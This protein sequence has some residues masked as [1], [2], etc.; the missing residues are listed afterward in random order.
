MRKLYSII[1]LSFFIASCSP[2]LGDN[3]RYETSLEAEVTHKVSKDLNSHNMLFVPEFM[4]KFGKDIGYF[5]SVMTHDQ[6]DQLLDLEANDTI[7]PLELSDA[8]IEEGLDDKYLV[9]EVVGVN[10]LRTGYQWN[11]T[12]PVR[13]ELL[14]SSWIQLNQNDPK[15]AFGAVGNSLI[16]Y[17][18]ENAQ[19]V[20][21]KIR[22]ERIFPELKYGYNTTMSVVSPSTTS[23][24]KFGLGLEVYGEYRFAQ[25]LAVEL[26]LNYSVIIPF[27]QNDTSTMIFGV[28]LHLKWYLTNSFDIH[29]G[30]KLNYV[31]DPNAFSGHRLDVIDENKVAWDLLFGLGYNW[32]DRVVVKFDYSKGM[33]ELGKNP[34]SG[35]REGA[36]PLKLDTFSLGMGLK[37]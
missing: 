32:G 19:K 26:G 3:G 9:L 13:G 31:F 12:D 20:P 2:K 28:P 17:L 7:D 14:F 16:D 10:S 29:A 5:N 36:L 23:H 33:S 22:E 34:V 1:F 37:F 18:D 6:V 35:G 25:L 30:P 27:Q 15:A 8:L 11:L 21:G 24:T 4:A